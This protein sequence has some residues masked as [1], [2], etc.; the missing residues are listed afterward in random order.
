MYC[1]SCKRS[2]SYTGARYC[3]WCG[4]P[5]QT[6]LWSDTAPAIREL[7]LEDLQEARRICRQCGKETPADSGYCVRCG[8]AMGELVPARAVGDA[9]RSRAAEMVSDGQEAYAKGQRDRARSLCSEAL[10]LDPRNAQGHALLA[11]IFREGGNL[12]DAL[13]EMTTALR[14]DPE[15]PVLV[16]RLRELREEQ[17]RAIEPVLRVLDVPEHRPRR[18][19]PRRA[20]PP[21]DLLRRQSAPRAEVQ[22]PSW[23]QPALI[24]AGL[25]ALLLLVP[26]VMGNVVLVA[27]LILTLLV[28][29][30]VFQDATARGMSKGMVLLWTV[31]VITTSILGLLMY[32]IL[33]RRRH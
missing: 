8:A 28:G 24:V 33:T 7:A 4:A 5:L 23:L 9:E 12:G 14:Y 27:G 16:R 2:T 15:N 26:K 30:F 32:L 20:R 22:W 29:V 25:M 10:A 18:R 19:P 31:I 1:V 3:G 21:R 6:P 11:D 17:D 13:L